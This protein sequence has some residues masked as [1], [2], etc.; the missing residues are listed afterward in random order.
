MNQSD[1]D[2]TGIP[3][4][5]GGESGGAGLASRSGSG[6][7]DGFRELVSRPLQVSLPGL[8]VLRLRVNRHHSNP[9]PEPVVH[10]HEHDQVLLYLLGQGALRI[11]GDFFQATAG[12]ALLI[13]AGQ[14]HEFLR[15]S[16][17]R[18]VCVAV[19]LHLVGTDQPACDPAEDW[20]QRAELSATD[21]ALVRQRLAPL[22]RD[23]V[24][25]SEATDDSTWPGGSPGLAAAVL[26]LLHVVLRRLRRE[27]GAEAVMDRLG[28]PVAAAVR[29]ILIAGLDNGA[30]PDVA[31][32][33]RQLNRRAVHLSR[34]LKAECGLTLGQLRAAVLLERAKQQLQGDGG[35]SIGEVG[36]AVGLGDANYFSRWFR[37]QTGMSPGEWRRR[38]AP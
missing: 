8:M 5:V 9:A 25:A 30:V 17:R 23:G 28:G 1:T 19:D 13:R 2:G 33:A 36:A 27:P 10:R 7:D 34:Q 21:L 38:H 15:R 24:L 20:L 16:P 31:G 35:I 3:V 29:R 26:D 12:T 14:E 11:G 22:A 37:R 6:S 32:V 4:Q 18:P